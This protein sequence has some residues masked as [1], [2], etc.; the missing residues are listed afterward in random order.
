MVADG[1]CGGAAGVCFGVD[2]GGAGRIAATDRSGA[3]SRCVGE[4]VPAHAAE[5]GAGASTDSC[6]GARGALTSVRFTHGPASGSSG[7]RGAAAEVEGVRVEGNI[8]AFEF[9]WMNRES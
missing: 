7:D 9:V 1:G 5:R 8:M 6:V 3:Y 2:G 4:D